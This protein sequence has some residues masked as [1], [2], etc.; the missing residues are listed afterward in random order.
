MIKI[1]GRIPVK[2]RLP[3]TAWVLAGLVTLFSMVSSLVH[4]TPAPSQALSLSEQVTVP[5]KEAHQCELVGRLRR[6]PFLPPRL[7]RFMVAIHKRLDTPRALYQRQFQSK[8]YHSWDNP[9]WQFARGI[10]A[11]VATLAVF[12]GSARRR[13]CPL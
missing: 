3:L 9:F 2:T 11:G 12:A 8:R 4:V 1:T 10:A 6:A 13:E 5:A 7:P